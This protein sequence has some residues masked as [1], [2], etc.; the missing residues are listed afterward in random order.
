M[1]IVFTICEQYLF[2]SHNT[3]LDGRL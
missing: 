1:N 2:C 3:W